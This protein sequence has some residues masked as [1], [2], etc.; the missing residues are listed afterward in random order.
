MKDGCSRVP[1]SIWDGRAAWT[2]KG[3]IPRGKNHRLLLLLP[4]VSVRLM[5]ELAFMKEVHSPT[6]VDD[7]DDDPEEDDDGDSPIFRL[8]VSISLDVMARCGQLN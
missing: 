8:K 1:G 3:V 2:R 5:L 4:W 6:H 7:E